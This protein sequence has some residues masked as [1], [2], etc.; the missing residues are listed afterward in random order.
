MDALSLNVLAQRLIREYGT[1]MTVTRVTSSTF[2]PTLG[3]YTSSTSTSFSVY[4]VIR[5]PQR[6]MWAGDRYYFG[7]LIESGDREL[8]VATPT[9]VTIEVGDIFKISGVD[10][11]V[12]ANLTVEPAGTVVMYKVLV[13]R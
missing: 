2:S 6:R 8:A 3:S 12:V 10:Y 5:V 7:V 13:R 4:G 1:A 9:T 11:R